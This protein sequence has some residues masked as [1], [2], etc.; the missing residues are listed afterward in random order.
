MLKY[1]IIKI[2]HNKIAWEGMDWF[3]LVQDVDFCEH[4]NE[5]LGFLKC[6]EIFS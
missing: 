6:W 5:S 3:H 1:N 2:D 4:D